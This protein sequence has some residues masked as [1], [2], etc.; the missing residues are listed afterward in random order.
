[1]SLGN[2]NDDE[3]GE[4]VDE[5]QRVGGAGAPNGEARMAERSEG[6]LERSPA[7]TT[8]ANNKASNP[9]H[10][11]RC[12]ASGGVTAKPTN[13]D[14]FRRVRIPIVVLL[15]LLVSGTEVPA[16][17]LV[18]EPGPQQARN[19][20]ARVDYNLTFA[21][22]PRLGQREAIQGLRD[23]APGLAVT[24]DRTTGATRTLLSR[25][26]YLTAARPTADAMTIAL[27]FVATYYEHLGMTPA[28][29]ADYEVTDE[30]TSDVTGATHI[31]LRQT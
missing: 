12:E 14:R 18:A 15:S 13:A 7:M 20:D 21:A 2:L 24:Y 27:D 6:L 26:G 25:G 31:Y 1:M 29:I 11:H 22:A 19:F 17:G 10:F 9:K 5:F 23:A 4:I 30:V 3:I 16:Q 8:G 28:D